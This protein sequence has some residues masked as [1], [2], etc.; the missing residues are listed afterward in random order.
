MQ[1]NTL[2]LSAFIL[3]GTLANAAQ[4]DSLR[5]GQRHSFQTEVTRTAGA[6]NLHRHTEQVAGKHQIQRT[7]KLA[8]GQGKT[9]SRTVQGSYDSATKTYTRT[10]DSTRPNGDTVSSVGQTSKTDDGVVRSQTRTNAAGEVATKEVSVS[11]DQQNQVHTRTVEASG[12]NGQ[13][14][15]ASVS[16][17]RAEGGD[18]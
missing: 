12:Y 4:A 17:S 5:L 18:Q 8:T 1:A 15:S 13:S 10:M 7:T 16:R 11:V 6:R 3:A 14:Y 9:A 2:I